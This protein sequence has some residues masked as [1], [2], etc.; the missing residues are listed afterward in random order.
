[1][2]KLEKENKEVFK[3]ISKKKAIYL[4]KSRAG[5][6]VDALFTHRSV[7]TRMATDKGWEDCDVF[8]EITSSVMRKPELE[9][10]WANI[11]K[12]DGILA[13]NIHRFS[14]D[15]EESFRIEKLLQANDIIIYTPNGNYDLKNKT[16]SFRFSIESILGAEYYNEVKGLMRDGKRNRFKNGEY[17]IGKPPFGYTIVDKRLQIVE[18]EAELV[19]MVFQLAAQGLGREAISDATGNVLTR[20]VIRHMLKNRTYI[21]T[22]LYEIGVDELGDPIILSHSCPAI[23]D[24]ELW[25]NVQEEL[26]RRYNAPIVTRGTIRSIVQGLIRCSICNCQMPITKNGILRCNT[27]KCAQSGIKV[28]YIEEH[29]SK[30]LYT[31]QWDIRDYL[32]ERAERSEPSNTKDEIEAVTGHI[33]GLNLKLIR[34]KDMYTEGDIDKPDFK[35]R[36]ANID[37]E[38]NE[39][40]LKLKSLEIKQAREEDIGITYFTQ[41]M[42]DLQRFDT[43]DTVTDRHNI[44]KKVVDY[45]KYNR[46]VPSKVGSRARTVEEYPPLIEIV[47]RQF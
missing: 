21:G 22:A 11:E 9:K 23:I 17:S 6:E 20:N 46:D 33:E 36:K 26:K 12:Y 39:L 41:L 44:V 31:R 40:A 3:M 13:M 2:V 19:R 29:I 35:E 10:L 8:E 14:R 15:K 24:I 30:E 5:E 1:M 7:L 18:E 38:M 16:D 34:V 4:R 42:D 37:S 28:D 32:M 47:Y 45:I 43:I 27:P 25:V